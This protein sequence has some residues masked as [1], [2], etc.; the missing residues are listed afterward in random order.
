VE[1]KSL[2]FYAYDLPNPKREKSFSFQLW[3]EGQG[4]EPTTYKLGLLRPDT[5]GHGRWVVACDDPKILGHLR[6]VFIAP[7]STK[8]DPPSPSQKLMYAMLGSANHP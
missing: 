3:G 6:G 4:L 2:V 7:A 8:G 1:G 5:S